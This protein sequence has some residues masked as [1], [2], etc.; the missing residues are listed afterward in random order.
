[1]SMLIPRIY[2]SDVN[3]LHFLYGSS[4]ISHSTDILKHFNR[5]NQSVKYLLVTSE[6]MK[7]DNS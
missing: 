5:V 4:I 6:M 7:N 1:M 3:I 2:I